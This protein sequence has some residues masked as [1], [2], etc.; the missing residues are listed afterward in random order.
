M[1]C[2]MPLFPTWWC[3]A[4]MDSYIDVQGLL[5]GLRPTSK[6][7]RSLNPDAPGTN[8]CRVTERVLGGKDISQTIHGTGTDS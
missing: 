2:R 8:D 5:M 6:T 1:V 4:H 7:T 3:R